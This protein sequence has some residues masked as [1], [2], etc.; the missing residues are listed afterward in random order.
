MHWKENQNTET[1]LKQGENVTTIKMAALRS[2][3]WVQMHIFL[4]D[5]KALMWPLTWTSL[6][7]TVHL[8]IPFRISPFEVKVSSLYTDLKS[9]YPKISTNLNQADALRSEHKELQLST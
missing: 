1:K 6:E 3:I 4:L 7:Q 2:D 9:N 5:Q 8:P